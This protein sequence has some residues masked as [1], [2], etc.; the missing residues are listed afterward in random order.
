MTAVPYPD[1]DRPLDFEEIGANR[2]SVPAEWPEPYR[3]CGAEDPP[4]LEVTSGHFVRASA[5]PEIPAQ[6]GVAARV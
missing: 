1:P 6:P 5:L 4:M 3:C 2:Q